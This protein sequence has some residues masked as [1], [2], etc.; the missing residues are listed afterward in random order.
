M[1]IR[2]KNTLGEEKREYI[3]LG[4]K[5]GEWGNDLYAIWRTVQNLQEGDLVQLFNSESTEYARVLESV[6][7]HD[8]THDYDMDGFETRAYNCEEIACG[9][10]LALFMLHDPRIPKV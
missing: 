6:K 2:R 5:H 7:W 3:R 1:T 10:H 4:K 9:L 8:A